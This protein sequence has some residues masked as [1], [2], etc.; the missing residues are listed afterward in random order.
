MSTA[1]TAWLTSARLVLE[2][3]AIEE[4]DSANPVLFPLVYPDLAQ[5]WKKGSTSLT[6]Q[7]LVRTDVE[8]WAQFPQ[9]GRPRGGQS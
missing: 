2:S 6:W 5:R 8:E 3:P 4:R 1:S 9:A 7:V